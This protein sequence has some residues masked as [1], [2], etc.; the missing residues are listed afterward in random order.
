MGGKAEESPREALEAAGHRLS[1]QPGC[2]V[3]PK[4]HP[5]PQSQRH[6]L[7]QVH[8]AVSASV[9]PRELRLSR[10]FKLDEIQE[11]T[12]GP[13]LGRDPALRGERLP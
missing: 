12:T 9:L 3:K 1:A 11:V 13:P 10:R 6:L 5:K 7:I 4:S 8:S 2:G